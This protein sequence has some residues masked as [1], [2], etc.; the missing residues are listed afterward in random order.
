MTLIYFLVQNK[1]YLK[2]LRFHTNTCQSTLYKKKALKSPNRQDGKCH[3]TPKFYCE[4]PSWVHITLQNFISIR[5]DSH[6]FFKSCCN[7]VS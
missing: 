2:K 1:F 3:P 4:T 6:N 7:G 5:Y